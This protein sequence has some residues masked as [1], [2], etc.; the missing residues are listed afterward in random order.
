MYF[1]KSFRFL[2]LLNPPPFFLHI[3]SLEEEALRLIAKDSMHKLQRGGD[4]GSGG[5][6]RT[7]EHVTAGSQS[8]RLERDAPRFGSACVPLSMAGL[9]AGVTGCLSCSSSF[10]FCFAFSSSPAPFLDGT[11]DHPFTD[12]ILSAARVLGV[13]WT[14]CFR[15]TVLAATPTRRWW[16]TGMPCS[17]L[18]SPRSSSCAGP[19]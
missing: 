2:V 11:P 14:P 19:R 5:G 15:R 9:V 6:T 1:C 13:V 12:F 8:L 10:K 17:R 4:G 16:L 18:T 3:P 7:T